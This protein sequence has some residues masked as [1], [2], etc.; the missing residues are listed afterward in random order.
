[1]PIAKQFTVMMENRPGA[2][3]QLCSELAKVAVNIR[4]IDS[5]QGG[6]ALPVRLLVSHAEAAR[7]VFSAMGLEWSE[8]DVLAIH[9]G[10]R[11]GALGKITRKLA[12]RGINV[13][14][15]YATIAK[16]SN[17]ALVVLAVSDLPAA[18]RLMH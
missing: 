2:L 11:P 1:M 6:P 13:N 10:E 16:N 18:S 4:A 5:G 17:R 12:E 14:H 15:I 9:V 8:E 3:A 7:K